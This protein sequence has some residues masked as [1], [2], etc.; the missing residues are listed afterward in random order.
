M[1]L[2]QKILKVLESHWVSFQGQDEHDV[3]R[4]F[5]NDAAAR[6]LAERISRYGT[7][8]WINAD[9]NAHVREAKAIKAF[10]GEDLP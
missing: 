2:E 7:S 4:S 9:H 1:T 10:I 6:D 8:V 3:V 5:D